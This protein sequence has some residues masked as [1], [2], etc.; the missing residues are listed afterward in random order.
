[1]VLPL[2]TRTAHGPYWLMDALTQRKNINE[3]AAGALD[4]GRLSNYCELADCWKRK[5]YLITENMIK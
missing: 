4:L 2:N 1:M 3:V 5:A